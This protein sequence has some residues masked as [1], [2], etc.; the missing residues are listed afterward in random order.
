MNP[1]EATDPGDILAFW[2][3]EAGPRRWFAADPVFDG[4]VRRRFARFVHQADAFLNRHGS[5]MAHPWIMRADMA[6]A[7]LIAI[8]QFPRNIF[9]GSNR[10]FSLDPYAAEGARAAVEFGYD[11]DLPDEAR[12]FVYMPLM[13]AEDLEDQELC[14]ALCE[15]RL[16]ADDANTLRHARAHRDV[17]RRFGR[18]PHRNALLG[19]P[20]TP[21]EAAYLSAGG[22]RPG[23]RRPAKNG[24]A[25]K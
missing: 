5:V 11:L 20:S 12:A 10:A 22:Y 2:F 7:L 21:D 3:D 19:R 24:A 6:L 14:V 23:A 13:H 9:R 18:F 17:I 4:K 15:A 16:P 25:A 1:A 8:D